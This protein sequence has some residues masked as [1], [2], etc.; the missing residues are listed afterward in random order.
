MHF[1]IIIPCFNEA[2]NI[3]PLLDEINQE[4][5][6]FDYE[7]I[8]IDDKSTDNS[9]EI[10]KKNNHTIKVLENKFNKGQSFCI[11]KGV[12][13]SNSNTIVTID[14]DGQN[15]PAD[16]KKLFLIYKKNKTVKL[17]GGIRN[18]RIDN[19][20]KIISSKIANSIRKFILNDD[21]IDTGCGLKVFD[22]KVFLTLPFF[23]G[24]HRFLPAL[25]KGKKKL[26]KFVN[27]DHRA[28]KYGISKYGNL[29]RAIF[30]AIDLVRVYYI[31]KGFNND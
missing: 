24:I 10:I 12:K 3:P 14:C 19:F 6:D 15:N 5:I 2:K 16:I 8:I 7:I 21:C 25:Y 26:T 30:G 31:I 18:K 13:I 28:R 11:S 27:V 9:I 23:D 20:T 1:S 4:L 22:K 17:V 29:K